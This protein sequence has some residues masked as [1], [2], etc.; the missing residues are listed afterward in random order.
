[1]YLKMNEKE[2]D[3]NMLIRVG[4]ITFTGR[5]SIL[6]QNDFIIACAVSACLPFFLLNRRHEFHLR[7]LNQSYLTCHW[8]RAL[9]ES[10]SICACWEWGKLECASSHNFKMKNKKSI[11]AAAWHQPDKG[12]SLNVRSNFVIKYRKPSKL[13]GS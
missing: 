7:I 3:F 6:L 13:C 2:G 12:I 9:K 10:S 5:I 11:K 8:H 1:M 4:E